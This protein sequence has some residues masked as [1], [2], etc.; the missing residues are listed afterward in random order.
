MRKAQKLN[1]VTPDKSHFSTRDEL[2]GHQN[3]Q[4]A[5]DVCRQEQIK[6]A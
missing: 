6:P 4:R 1:S 2:L 3:V 5:F